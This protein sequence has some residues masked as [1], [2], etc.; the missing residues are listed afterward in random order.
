MDGHVAIPGADS[1]KIRQQKH[2]NIKKYELGKRSVAVL[3]AFGARLVHRQTAFAVATPRLGV[4]PIELV[5]TARV[6]ETDEQGNEQELE[7]VDHHS[8]ERYLS[9]FIVQK[10]ILTIQGES[11]A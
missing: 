2:S 3:F 7:Y 1:D 9:S 8:T 4:V 11:E 6:R 5:D 10:N